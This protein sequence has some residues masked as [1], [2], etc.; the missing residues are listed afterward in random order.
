VRDFFPDR[1]APTESGQSNRWP[2]GADRLGARLARAW[3]EETTFDPRKLLA[4]VVSRTLP[5]FSFSRTRTFALR[6]AGVRIGSRSGI[7]GPIDITGAGDVRE[8]FSIGEDT[9]I[10]GP[11]HVDLGAEVRIGSRVQ[12]GHHVVLLTINHEVGPSRARCG[13]Q[14]AAPIVIGDGVWIASRV[15]VLPGVSIG[16]GSVIAAGA[17]VSRDVEPNTLVAGVPA[18]LVRVLEDGVPPRSQR[19]STYPPSSSYPPPAQEAP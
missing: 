15:T 12:L 18:R 1:S 11:L 5:Q 6:A 10:S 19:W 3:L 13:P 14:V 16:D 9:F 8:L 17:V 4:Q 7:L 2:R